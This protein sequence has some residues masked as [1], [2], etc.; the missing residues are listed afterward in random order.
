MNTTETR[1]GKWYTETEIELLASALQL[2]REE[3]S[4]DDDHVHLCAFPMKEVYVS[5]PHNRAQGGW[6]CQARRFLYHCQGK[7]DKSDTYTPSLMSRVN[8]DRAIGRRFNFVLSHGGRDLVWSELD[9]KTDKP[10]ANPKN[11]RSPR[12]ESVIAADTFYAA[13]NPEA[14]PPLWHKYRAFA[15]A[16]KKDFMLL[17]IGYARNNGRGEVQRQTITRYLSGGV[18][19]DENPTGKTPR[20]FKNLLE[21]FYKEHFGRADFHSI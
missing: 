3:I 8:R 9:P 21:E 12:G 19:Y 7:R 4:A 1:E 5:L 14:L 13:M 18:D 6:S 11:R 15:K 17:A 10:Y 20:W 16:N 2:H